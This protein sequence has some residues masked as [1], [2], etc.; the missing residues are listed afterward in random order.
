MKKLKTILIIFLFFMVNN[1]IFAQNISIGLKNGINKSTVKAGDIGH[2]KVIS[3]KGDNFGL[4]VN[5]KFSGLVFL[6]TGLDFEQKGFEFKQYYSPGYIG[7]GSYWGMYKLKYI[8]IPLLANI[9]FGKS[10]KY[11]GY[12]G[13]YMSLLSNAENRTTVS[14]I[15]GHGILWTYDHSYDPTS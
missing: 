2:N 5:Y 3:I 9:E 12:T 11:Y 10:I 7:D 1:I 8:T 6:L 13:L 14:I 4:I 15:G